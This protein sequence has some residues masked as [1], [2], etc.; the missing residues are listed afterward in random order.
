M[1]KPL[2]SARFANNAPNTLFGH[3]YALVAVD[4]AHA[5]RKH[6]VVH[7][8]LRALKEKTNVLVAMTAT[9][10]TTRPQVS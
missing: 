2:E 4:E 8:A 9:P 10:V 5:A 3:Q 6:N 1:G 7:M